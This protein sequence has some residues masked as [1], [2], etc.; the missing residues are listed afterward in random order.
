MDQITYRTN[1]NTRWGQGNGA[2]LTATQIDI[3]FWVLYTMLLSIQDHID[4][5]AGISYITVTDNQMTVHLSNHVALGPF[6]LPTATWNF[7]GTWQADT[8]YNIN[9]VF[10]QGGALYLVTWMVANS[11]ATFN[12]FAN[13]GAGHNWYAQILAAPPSE[14]PGTGNP[15]AFLQMTQ[16]NSPAS[17]TWV[18]M[19]RNLAMYI[20]SPPNPLE[21]V[22]AYVFTE[23]TT[24]AAGLPRSKAHVLTAPTAPQAYELYQNGANIGSV[25]FTVSPENPTFTFP[26]NIVF[27]PGDVLTIVAPSVPDAHMT[28]ICFTLVGEVNQLGSPF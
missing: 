3:N 14:L 16:L 1:D 28:G 7:R 25:N 21:E 20:E 6:I 24:F 22:L 17:A 5:N 19:T 2:D 4:T 10:T 27:N 13:D 18:Q 8:N 23:T 12:Q 9:D 11:G 26:T 15:G